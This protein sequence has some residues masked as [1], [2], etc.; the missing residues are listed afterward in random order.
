MKQSIH[1]RLRLR[2]DGY[3]LYTVGKELRNFNVSLSEFLSLLEELEE[4]VETIA[5]KVLANG[6]DYDDDDDD[7]DSDDDDEEYDEEGGGSGSS[8]D[9]D[10]LGSQEDQSDED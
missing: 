3:I 6:Y 8:V 9:Y 4:R 1:V 10:E 2:L 5:D 7:A